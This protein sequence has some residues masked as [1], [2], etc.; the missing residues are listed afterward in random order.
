MQPHVHKSRTV[1]MY[2]H[3]EIFDGEIEKINKF[4][5]LWR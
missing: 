4:Y 2:S 1:Q 3:S 5:V